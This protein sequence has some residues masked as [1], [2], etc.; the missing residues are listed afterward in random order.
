MTIYIIEKKIFSSWIKAIF[1]S[2]YTVI[3]LSVC[4]VYLEA[5]KI[6]ESN[7]LAS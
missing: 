5:V 1:Y 3:F 7:A 4:L 2:L 6:S